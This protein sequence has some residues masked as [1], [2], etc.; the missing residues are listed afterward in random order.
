MQKWECPRD[1]WAFRDVSLPTRRVGCERIPAS[2]PGLLTLWK[3]GAGMVCLI[4]GRV[5]ITVPGQGQPVA[6]RAC[7]SVS[8]YPWPTDL[9]MTCY[10]RYTCQPFAIHC[11]QLCVRLARASSPRTRE[12]TAPASVP[13]LPASVATAKSRVRSEPSCV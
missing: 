6:G 7:L 13:S 1:D 3:P 5:A 2:C 8:G 11:L 10:S 4:R 9:S 12:W